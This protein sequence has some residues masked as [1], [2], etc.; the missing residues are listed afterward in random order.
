MPR[1]A[2]YR[3]QSWPVQLQDGSF[4]NLIFYK[5][6]AGILERIG[7]ANLVSEFLHAR[8]FPT[9]ATYRKPIIRLQAGNTVR[10]GALYNYLP[11]STIPWE[12][13]TKDHIKLLGMVLSDMH[14]ALAGYK[15]SS[16]RCIAE[17]YLQ[18]I[19]RMSSYFADAGVQRALKTKLDITVDP[20]SLRACR[21]ILTVCQRL[22]GQHALHMDFVRGNVLFED[23]HD[24]TPG[25]FSIGRLQVSGILDF[26]K[27][28]IGHP[29]LDIARTL[30]FLLVDCKYKLP[31]KTKKYFLQ[32]GYGKRGA[33]GF[34]SVRTLRRDG[35]TADLL[36]GLVGLFLLHDLYKFL[37]HNPYE[38]LAQNHHYVRTRDILVGQGLIAGPNVKMYEVKLMG[39]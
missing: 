31:S 37:R 16:L 8:G 12:A 25:R 35:S 26:E 1:Q 14:A 20:E 5:P 6:E 15:P 32:S 3:S 33:A 27:T 38:S 30:A 34:H 17:E 28:G 13:Y 11:G 23:T 10:Y 24:I 9:R 21:R 19:E 4:A 36:N 22:P 39:V 29:A 7:R 18:T 2:G